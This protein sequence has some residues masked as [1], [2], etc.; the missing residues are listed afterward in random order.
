MKHA[1]WRE[2]RT[3]DVVAP[4]V[5][6][7]EERIIVAHIW[8][9]VVAESAR[10]NFETLAKLLAFIKSAQPRGWHECRPN[11]EIGLKNPSFVRRES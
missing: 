1:P 7:V 10:A 4:G 2:V 11:S 3:R 8:P 9:P 5:T 6:K